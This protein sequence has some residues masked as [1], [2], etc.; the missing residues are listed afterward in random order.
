MDPASGSD[1]G[2]STP[3]QGPYEPRFF[4][5]HFLLRRVVALRR[6]VHAAQEVLEGRAG[7]QGLF[8]LCELPLGLLQD[9][10]VGVGVFPE[11]EEILI[12]GAGLGAGVRL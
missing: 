2:G 8:Q 7:A 10:D 9:G 12:G 11:R 3:G 6:E 1:L 4:L 5:S